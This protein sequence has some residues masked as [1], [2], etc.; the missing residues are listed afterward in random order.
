MA[1]VISFEL[2]RYPATE[3]ISEI[4]RHASMAAASAVLPS[5]AYTTLRT[6]SGNHV[7]RLN[8]HF[9]R[10]EE[11]TALMGQR[12][13]IND[14]QA[15]DAIAQILV[16]TGAE[17]WPAPESR[18]R[19]TFAPPQL[20]ITIEPFQPYPA[21]LYNT[22]VRCVSVSLHRDTPHAKST[23]FIASAAEAYQALPAGTHEGL[24]IAE[25]GSILEGLSSNFFAIAEAGEPAQATLFTEERRVLIGVTR[26]LVLE[27]AQKI[28]P[29]RNSAIQLQDLTD[30]TLRECFITSVSREI[31]PVV[32]IDAVPIGN[33]QPG[34]IT[35]ILMHAMATLIQNE[36]EPVYA[37]PSA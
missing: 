2:N 37:K 26:S 21:S 22:G 33:G 20:F 17:S 12:G 13:R 36:A 32:Q 19:L 9:R 10:L 35:R 24:M 29:V 7:L 6:Y 16:R 34:P 25:D 8:Q 30:G 23:R 4:G 18:L 14:A 1:T 5:G 28:L 27:V 3:R 31:L 11:S 15:R